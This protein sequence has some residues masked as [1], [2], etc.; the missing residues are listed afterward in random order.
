MDVADIAWILTAFALV[1]VMFPGLSFLYGGMLGSGQVLNMFMMVMSSLA[2][3]A[4]VY[5]AYGHG[6]VMGNSVGGWGLIGNPLEYAGFTSLMTDDGAGGLLWGGFYI[7][8]AAISLALV[9]SGAAGRMKFGAWLIFGALWITIVYA[10][11]A[12]WVFAFDDPDAGVVGGWLVNRVGMHD[13]AGGTAIHMNAGAAGLALAL[14][15]GRRRTGPTRPHNLPL[16]L[17]GAGLLMI[18]W[19]GFNGGTAG[20]AN[21]LAT[22]VVVTSL[23]AVAGGMLGAIVVEKLRNGKPTL[24]GLATGVIAG[25]VGITPAADAVNPFGA[26]AVG[27]L[28]AAAALWAITWKARHGIDDSLDVFAVHGIAGIVGAFFVMLLGSEAAPAG[29]RGVLLGGD[30]SLLWREPL[31]VVVTLVWSFGLTWLI[32]TAMMRIHDIRISRED[33]DAGTDRSQ[34]AETAYEQRTST[35]FGTASRPADTDTRSDREA[36]APTA[37]PTTSATG[38]TAI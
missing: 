26:L 31:A 37:A 35:M 15:L 21:F 2:I 33:E 27:F 9:A 3:T 28:A 7:L 38:T 1:A 20:G 29:V 12:H 11:L 10:P 30:V 19:F 6:L 23:L 25:L 32:A 8:F 16:V 17:I 13:F 22:Y 5:V 36:A 4:V 14:V 34:H 24:L 18:G